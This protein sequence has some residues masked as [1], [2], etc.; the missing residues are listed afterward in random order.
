M[1]TLKSLASTIGTAVERLPSG[2]IARI[3]AWTISFPPASPDRLPP[4][5][6]SK[7]YTDKPLVMVDGEPM[8]GELAVARWL[9]ED[10]WTAVW[11]DTFHGRKFWEGMPHLTSAVALPTPVRT[12]YDDIVEIKGNAW[13][14]FDVI[15]WKDGRTVFLEYKGPNDSPNKNEPSWIDAALQA[16]VREDDLFFVG[17]KA[18]PTTRGEDPQPS[19]ER[20]I[21]PASP[22]PARPANATREP[23]VPEEYFRNPGV[24]EFDSEREYLGWLDMNPSGYVLNVRGRKPLLH[25]ATCTHIDRHNNPGA[26]VE[27]GARKVCANER[28]ALARWARDEGLISSVILPKCGSCF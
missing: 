20:V 21:Q 4:G 6:L 1:E 25:K 10:G 28:D 12:V 16:G 27:R 17:D 23:T 3:A 26:L 19:P 15:A 14:C 8:F 7:T 24:Q 5:T 13:G 9:A 2:R 18:R 22:R 11:A